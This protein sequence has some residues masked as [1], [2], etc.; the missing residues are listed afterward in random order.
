MP[1][2]GVAAAGGGVEGCADTLNH[3]DARPMAQAKPS[4]EAATSPLAKCITTLVAR[5]PP[6]TPLRAVAATETSGPRPAPYA[7]SMV[8]AETRTDHV[9]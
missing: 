8:V 9:W 3:D 6:P 4:P 2:P 7:A 5:P 1:P